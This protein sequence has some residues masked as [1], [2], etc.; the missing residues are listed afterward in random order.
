MAIKIRPSDRKPALAPRSRPKPA[1][2][3]STL[4]SARR[5]QIARRNGRGGSSPRTAPH[6]RDDLIWAVVSWS[7]ETS[8]AHAPLPPMPGVE[9]AHGR[10]GGARRPSGGPPSF[11]IP[12]PCF[13]SLTPIRSA[14]TRTAARR[15]IRTIWCAVQFRA[16]K[17]GGTGG[18]QSSATWRSI[19]IPATAMT[20][21][22]ATAVVINDETV[23]ML[24]KAGR[25]SRPRPAATHHR[26]FRHDGRAAVGRDSAPAL[27]QADFLRRLDHGPMRRNMPRRSTVPFRADAVGSSATLT[28]DKA[29]LIRWIRPTT[30]EALREVEPRQSPKAADMGH[31]QGPACPILDILGRVRETAFGVA[32]L[33]LP[34]V[35]RIFHDHGGRRRMAGFDGEKGDDGKSLN[36]LQSVAGAA[37]GAPAILPPR[38]RGRN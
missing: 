3:P 34:G 7:M 4:R 19:H 31:G 13:V 29:H 2:P 14:A 18:R 8:T 5:P 23:E 11:A 10:P 26:A 27:D 20:G 28:G 33:R 1:H 17:Q 35:G 36:R 32:D 12:W 37:G 6:P 16:I 24:V 21:F 25:W 22:C 30:D 9:A 38:G 15:S